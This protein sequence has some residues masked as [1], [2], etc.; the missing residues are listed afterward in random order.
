MDGGYEA[1]V[2]LFLS[3]G[4]RGTLYIGVTNN[5]QRRVL[6]HRQGLIG[7][8]TKQYN[9]YRLVCFEQGESIVSAIEREKTLKHW[10]RDWKIA[11]VENESRSWRDLYIELFGKDA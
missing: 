8:F 4:Y 9:L 5:L 6:E 3:N 7:G 11:L 2:C 10:K 1:I